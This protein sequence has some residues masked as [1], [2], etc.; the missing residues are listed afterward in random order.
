MDTNTFIELL[1]NDNTEELY[2]IYIVEGWNKGIDFEEVYKQV[3]GID[4][5]SVNNIIG[6]ILHKHNNDEVN[7]TE[8]FKYYKLSA[9]QGNSMGQFNLG[10]IYFNTDNPQ[11]IGQNQNFWKA[12]KY[13]KLSSEQGN[14]FAHI[15]LGK[16]YT[17]CLNI[18]TD[19]K[20]ALKYCKLA[21]KSG[22][23][24]MQYAAARIYD[25]KCSNHKKAFKY[26]KLA[27]KQGHMDAQYHIG[28]MYRYGEGIEQ[29]YI[30]ALKY[31]KLA[32]DQGFRDGSYMSLKE[33]LGNLPDY[34]GKIKK[35]N[36]EQKLEIE[37]MRLK[38]EKMELEIEELRY[39]PGNVGYENA[40]KDF[41]EQLENI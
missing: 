4:N 38:I 15:Y 24:D 19:I 36:K 41:E 39:R 34:V 22:Y 25:I 37:R 26:Y 21:A 31:L 1:K 11:Y 29:D 6:Y 33:Q 2:K 28:F 14:I 7:E 30:K 12:S 32:E 8:I 9:K 27:A 17:N 5:G 18:N 16:L 20:E 3:R 10:I 35:E 13:L 40:R 23:R